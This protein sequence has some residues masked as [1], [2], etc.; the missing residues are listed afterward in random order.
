MKKFIPLLALIITASGAYIILSKERLPSSAPSTTSSQEPSTTQGAASD[1]SSSSSSAAKVAPVSVVSQDGV[2]SSREVQEDE[3]EEQIKPAADAYPSAEEALAAVLKGSK[4]YD[5]SVL[6]Q[7]TTP[8][9]SCTWCPEFYTSVR[10]LATNPNT[11]QEQRSYLAEILAISGRLE[12][13]QALVESIKTAPSNDAKDLYAEALELSM[14]KDDVTRYLGDQMNATDDTLREASVAAI[15][16]QGSKNAAELLINNLR[17][18][19]DIHGYY[20]LGMG[21]GEFIPDEDAIPVVQDYV[22]SRGP[23]AD[24]GVKALLNAGLPGVKAVFDELEHSSNPEADAPLIK[25]AL[26]HINME[27]GLIEYA[28]EVIA[29]N[30]SPTAVTLARQVIEAGQEAEESSEPS[31]DGELSE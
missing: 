11:P 27:D 29:R 13:V 26:D 6:E 2:V 31:S 25:G 10:D 15:T 5:D 22:H 9:Q 18:K 16:N 3:E 4:D 23:D 7:F 14:G 21:L 20:A 17:E 24:Q 1:S 28:N 30:Q 19:G 8:D 12:N